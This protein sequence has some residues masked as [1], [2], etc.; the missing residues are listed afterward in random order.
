MNESEGGMVG[1]WKY[2]YQLIVPIDFNAMLFGY[3]NT[4]L[5]S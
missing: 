3:A 2:V 1:K 5:G 4:A